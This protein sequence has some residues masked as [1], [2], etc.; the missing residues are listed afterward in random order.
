MIT[1]LIIGLVIWALYAS[2]TPDKKDHQKVREEIEKLPRIYF[3]GKE[4]GEIN[5]FLNLAYDDSRIMKSFL[6]DKGQVTLTMKNGT[7]LTAP[8]SSMVVYFQKAKLSPIEVTIHYRDRDIYFYEMHGLYSSKEYEV[9]Y[10]ILSLANTTYGTDI[11]NEWNKNLSKVNSIL[12]IM[13]Y[14]N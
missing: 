11:F 3:K 5:K 9:I 10:K 14:L 2:F 4:L 7:I 12:K 13:K 6:Y 1:I 8:L